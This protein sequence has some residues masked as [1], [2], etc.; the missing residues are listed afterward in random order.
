VN[1]LRNIEI[2][3]FELEENR[4]LPMVPMF[5]R[6]DDIYIKNLAVTAYLQGVYDDWMRAEKEIRNAKKNF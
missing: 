6:R 5:L 4:K 1:K 2:E 3:S